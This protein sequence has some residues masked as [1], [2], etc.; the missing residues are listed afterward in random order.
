MPVVR[1]EGEGGGGEEE[2]ERVVVV[3]VVGGR[4]R[5]CVCVFSCD[6]KTRL[7]GQMRATRC[8]TANLPK[9]MHG[10]YLSDVVQTTSFILD[11]RPL[12]PVVGTFTAR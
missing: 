5:G 3:V 4:G 9:L 6:T 11:H 2:G 10:R 12:H 1:G 8:Q 7:S